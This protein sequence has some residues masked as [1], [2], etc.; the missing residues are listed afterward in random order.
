MIKSLFRKS[1]IS[2]PSKAFS[3]IELSIVVLIIGILIAGVTQGS[4]LV[5]QSRL[6]TA[7]N[8]TQTSPVN[9]I[10]NLVGWWETTSANS[11]KD[12]EADE[13]LQPTAWYDNSSQSINKNNA[14]SSAGA[15]SATY[16]ATQINGLPGLVFPGTSVNQAFTLADP[17]IIN[18]SDYTI[19]V[20]ESHSA[21]PAKNFFLCGTVT[22]VTAAP[23][24][25]LFLG[26]STTGSN[27][28]VWTYSTAAP[29]NTTNYATGIPTIGL[30]IE[31]IHSYVHKSSNGASAK[32]YFISGASQTLGFNDASSLTSWTGASIG[33]GLAGNLFAGAI[34]EVIIYN[35]ALST[36]ERRSIEAYLSKKWAISVV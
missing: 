28:V 18:S 11:F 25:N 17:T 15:G 10:P 34:G 5:K 21:T 30:N 33:C 23:W 20:V 8:Q 29:S 7:Q 13:G 36:E 1:I 35:R 4:R 31:T 16:R 12:I 6:A 24:T 32:K 14:T 9:S 26:F 2:K 19:F 3:L 22:P 27:T